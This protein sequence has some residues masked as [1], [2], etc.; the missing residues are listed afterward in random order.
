MDVDKKQE[1]EDCSCGSREKQVRVCP[2]WLSTHGFICA[3]LLNSFLSIY[4][5]LHL[6]IPC[7]DVG[8]LFFFFSLHNTPGGHIGTL[9][10]I[11]RKIKY[12][13]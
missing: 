7:A 12:L 8:N 6:F 11:A 3:L 1:L 10:K 4:I 2:Y 13:Q 5:F 9:E